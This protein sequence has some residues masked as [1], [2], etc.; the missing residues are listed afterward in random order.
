M[1]DGTIPYYAN[2]HSVLIPNDHQF[3]C[4]CC[5]ERNS[6]KSATQEMLLTLLFESGW[7]CF[8]AYSAGFESMFYIVNQNCKSKRLEKISELEHQKRVAIIRHKAKDIDL[9]SDK[10]EEVKNELGCN[11]Y[12]RYPITILVNEAIDIDQVSLNRINGVYYSKDEWVSKMRVQGE[13]LVEYDDRSPPEKPKSERGA[14]WLKV[15]K[16]PTPNV[17]DNAKLVSKGIYDIIPV[18]QPLIDYI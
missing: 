18:S 7:T 6:G 14:E 11:C 12:K 8:D 5:G 2:N 17:K 9:I 3:L 1:I 16:L 4:V 10:I 13:I 15:V